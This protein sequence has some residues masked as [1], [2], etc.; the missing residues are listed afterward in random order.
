[1]P[2]VRIRIN[3]E[4]F[5]SPNPTTGRA[6]YDLAELGEDRELF[7]ETH[8][9][10]KDALIRRDATEVHLKEDEHLYSEKVVTIVVEGKPHRWPE[11]QMISYDQVVR[12]EIPKYPNGITYAVKYSDGPPR[13][14]EGPLLPGEKVKVKEGMIFNVSETGQ[15]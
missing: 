2:E 7:R 13:N 9:D 3:S 8:G 5:T 6:L 14:P 10:R 15:S 4:P 1:M 11:D 12:L